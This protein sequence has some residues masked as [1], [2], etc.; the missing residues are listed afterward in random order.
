MLQSSGLLG[1]GA[2]IFIVSVGVLFFWYRKIRVRKRL[3]MDSFGTFFLGG[4][5]IGKYLTA[6]NN[7]GICFAFAN[8][9]WYYA[10]LGYYF[11]IYVFLLQAAWSAAIVFLAKYLATYLHAS[12]DGTVHG[13]IGH[14]Y[15][16]RTSLLAAIATIIGYTLNIGFELFYSAHLLVASLGVQKYELIVAVLIAL[17]VGGYCVIGGYVSSVVTD[18]LQNWL[19]V[20]SILILLCLVMPNVLHGYTIGALLSRTNTTYPGTS[21]IVGV[22]VFSFFL[23]WWIWPIG[24]R[25]LLIAICPLSNCM[26]LRWDCT[27]QLQYRWSLLPPLALCLERHFA[28][29][30]QVSLMMGILA[31]PFDRYYHSQ[32][33]GAELF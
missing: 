11:G 2:A 24:N 1:S 20:I 22:V 14:H 18:P 26:M 15:G 33:H 4:G 30:L 16:T 10:F 8:A 27:A 32:R 21:F 7:W 29:Q 3:A 19:G 13:F 6:N 28:L 25:S 5:E 9:L 23:T 12:R 31:L 17:F